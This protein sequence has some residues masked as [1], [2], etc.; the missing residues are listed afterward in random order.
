KNTPWYQG[1]T[2]FYLLDTLPLQQNH[3]RDFI[4]PVQYINRQIPN[5]RAFCGNIASGSI[6]ID[7]EILILPSM[8][9]S[10]VKK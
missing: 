1:K 10:K 4:L 6:K 3:G 7:D 8:Q 5:V 9:T 2:L